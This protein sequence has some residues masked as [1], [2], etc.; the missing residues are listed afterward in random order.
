MVT[1]YHAPEG[2][3]PSPTAAAE[4]YTTSL[5]TELPHK[6]WDIIAQAVPGT[7]EQR[8]QTFLTNVQWDAEGLNRQRVMKMIAEARLE[9]GVLVLDDTGFP[10]Q[11]RALV[12]VTRQD[13]ESLG[14]V[15]KTRWR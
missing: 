4:R 5:L 3:P 11:E 6:N 15:G 12:G 10:K 13:S 1:D 9:D 7:S 14:K 8:L 2:S